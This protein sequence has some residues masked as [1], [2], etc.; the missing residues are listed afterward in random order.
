MDKLQQAIHNRLND[1]TMITST[2]S[3]TVSHDRNPETTP[4]T[5]ENPLV[6]F[7]LIWGTGALGTHRAAVNFTVEFKVWGYSQAMVDTCWSVANR[8]DLLMV[9]KFNISGGGVTLAPM[10][11]G[12]Q[13]V[14][15]PDPQVVHLHGRYSGRYW[16]LGRIGILTA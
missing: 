3:A 12:F 4:D 7:R 6:T 13:R 15:Q 14:D 5:L 11:E 10:V 16:S 9:S 1:D 2:Y 8:I